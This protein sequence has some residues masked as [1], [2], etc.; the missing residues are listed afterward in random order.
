MPVDSSQ[1]TT[2]EIRRFMTEFFSDEE[3]ATL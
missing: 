2:A 3:L 1:P